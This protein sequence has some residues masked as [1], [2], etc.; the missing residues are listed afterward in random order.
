MHLP[1][2]SDALDLRGLD[3]GALDDRLAGRADGSPPIPRILLAP[4]RLGRTNP[5]LRDRTLGPFD[6]DHTILLQKLRKS[7]RFK[8]I[9]ADDAVR[10]K[11]KYLQAPAVIDVQQH[12]GGARY[13]LHLSP[14]PPHQPAD[15]SGLAGAQVAV[16]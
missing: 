14:K 4:A 1:A 13:G 9:R 15:K 2:Q 11:V 3:P 6:D 8:I 7:D 16:Q 12:E 5:M 10:V